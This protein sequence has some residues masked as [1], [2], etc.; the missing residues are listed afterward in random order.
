MVVY[1][2]ED[3]VNTFPIGKRWIGA[4]QPCYI[5]A[6]LMPDKLET[7]FNTEQELMVFME[8]AK[9][10]GADAVTFHL[11]TH[12][13]GGP[14]ESAWGRISEYSKYMGIHF[15]P[16]I[17][18]PEGADFAKRLDVEGL[19]IL[20]LDPMLPENVPGARPY[21]DTAARKGVPLFIYSTADIPSNRLTMQVIEETGN[22]SIVLVSPPDAE[23][24][25]RNRRGFNRL[26]G[27]FI[28]DHLSQDD[29]ALLLQTCRKSGA[30]VVAR[31]GLYDELEGISPDEVTS[32]IKAIR[33]MVQ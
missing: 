1:R 28:K 31:W 33:E 24:V 9:L 15:I 30:S 19:F 17:W 4:N 20:A 16:R 22:R 18:N 21:L 27:C 32:S 2:K 11:E 12:P 8:A 3:I 23:T 13:Q 10:G 6:A 25:Q 14:Q 7:P 26:A 5:I 29:V